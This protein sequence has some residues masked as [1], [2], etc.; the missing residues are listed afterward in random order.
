[1]RLRVY[2]INAYRL[3]LVFGRWRSPLVARRHGGGAACCSRT[4]ARRICNA[5][6]VELV[7]A[8]T[9]M[10]FEAKDDDREYE[11]ADG[12]R[13]NNLKFAFFV[14]QSYSRD[15]RLFC[16][17]LSHAMN[18]DHRKVAKFLALAF[19]TSLS[20]DYESRPPSQIAYTILPATAPI[21]ARAHKRANTRLLYC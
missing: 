20:F 1:M 16:L 6:I 13:C 10:R 11:N 4:R 2:F 19:A 7:D 8:K 21:R 14:F 17:P 18:S 5:E 3:R 12:N 9:G 15:C